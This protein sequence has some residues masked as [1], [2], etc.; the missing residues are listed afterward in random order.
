MSKNTELG[1]GKLTWLA[2]KAI[3]ILASQMLA[4]QGSCTHN[5]KNPLVLTLFQSSAILKFHNSGVRSPRLKSQLYHFL[6]VGPQASYLT[7]LRFGFL[8]CKSGASLRI[9]FLTYKMRL[10]LVSTS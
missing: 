6:P 7:S 9:R 3:L 1:S 10:I 8:I 5:F 2:T 4:V